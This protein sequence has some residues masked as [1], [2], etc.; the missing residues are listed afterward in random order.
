MDEN[1][2]NEREPDPYADDEVQ[3]VDNQGIGDE[4]EV[5]IRYTIT[6]YGADYPVDGLVKRLAD[7]SILVPKFQRGYVWS[8]NQASRFVESLL[9]GLPVPGIFLSKEKESQKLLVI[10]GQQRLR[11]LQYF[12]EGSFRTHREEVLAQKGAEAI[13]RRDVQV[14]DRR[15]PSAP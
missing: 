3:I 13:P 8:A 11:T 6:S 14:A 4:A 1:E 2:A 10:D 5:P 7:E 9:L 15:R 12:Y